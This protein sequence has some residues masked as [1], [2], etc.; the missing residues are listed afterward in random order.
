MKDW[1]WPRKGKAQARRKFW[2]LFGQL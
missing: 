1:I 2:R